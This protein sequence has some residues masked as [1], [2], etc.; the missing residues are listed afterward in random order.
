MDVS[1]AEERAGPL[2]VGGV[3][4]GVDHAEAASRAWCASPSPRASGTKRSCLP[5]SKVGRGSSMRPQ[6][7]V[8]N[9]LLAG[10]DQLLHRPLD[11]RDD[12]ARC[13]VYRQRM[14]R[15]PL[16]VL[17]AGAVGVEERPARSKRSELRSVG[18]RPNLIATTHQP[19]RHA[20]RSR[21]PDAA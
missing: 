1:A 15:R 18:R 2:D 20:V 12:R 11:V 6:V 9:P 7:G 21:S 16:R 10:R 13:I 14:R 8:R 19:E 4:G 3:A 17:P 5:H